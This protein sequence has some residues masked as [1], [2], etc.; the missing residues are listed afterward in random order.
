MHI[1]ASQSADRGPRK[2]LGKDL[3]ASGGV[4]LCSRLS[5]SVDTCRASLEA[6]QVREFW[7]LMGVVLHASCKLCLEPHQGQL[8]AH[9]RTSNDCGCLGSLRGFH[10]KFALLWLESFIVST[11]S[12][13]KV[14]NNLSN[15]LTSGTAFKAQFILH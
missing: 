5:F 6:K 11:V 8:G 4:Y 14:R 15:L 9:P 13:L 12:W 1:R 3:E 7:E 2:A 10:L